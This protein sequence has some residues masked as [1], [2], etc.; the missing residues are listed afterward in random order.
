[1]WGKHGHFWGWAAGGRGICFLI[2]SGFSVR[3]EAR[4]SLRVRVAEEMNNL[5]RVEKA[6]MEK[7]RAA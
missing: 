6:S 1:M 2:A 4:L 5:R 7:Q 3:K